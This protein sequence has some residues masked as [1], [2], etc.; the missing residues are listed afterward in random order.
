MSVTTSNPSNQKKTRPKSVEIKT[1][2]ESA[3]WILIAQAAEESGLT[4]HLIRRTGLP[5]R[6]FGNADYIAPK[7]LNAWILNGEGEN[8]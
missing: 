7:A 2:P 6:R 8:Q 5:L 1:V 3:P 4:I